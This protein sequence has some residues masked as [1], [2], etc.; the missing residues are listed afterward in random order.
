MIHGTGSYTQKMAE[1]RRNA[2]SISKAK[3]QEIVKE[4]LRDKHEADKARKNTKPYGR[5]TD[6]DVGGEFGLSGISPKNLLKTIHRSKPQDAL[7]YEFQK[8]ADAV[9]ICARVLK[10]AGKKMRR[11]SK[12]FQ[13]LRKLSFMLTKSFTTGGAGT[14]AEFL[15]TEL[16]RSL[17]EL[18]RLELKV[19]ALHGR[20]NMP[21][22]P[23]EVPLEGIDMDVTL[24]GESTSDD[25][26]DSTELI[27]A[28]TPGSAKITFTAVKLALRTVWSEEVD[29]DSIIPVSDYTRTKLAQAM[30][31]GQEEATLTGDTTATH[32]DSDIT[33]AT[34]RRKAW[35]G[36][37]KL[38]PAAAKVDNGNAAVTLA[39]FRALKKA[40]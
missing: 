10:A 29:Q 30:G 28:D 2:G 4:I 5:Q 25:T 13:R 7:Q 38:A 18:V 17:I 37:R 32:Q 34:D 19:T 6:F 3:M 12:A 24:V 16:S 14:G 20:I 36:Y 15:P 23:F 9:Y 8:Q 40:M 27:P 22:N 26:R 35:D 39:N 11:T 1:L 33:A 31:N 21:T